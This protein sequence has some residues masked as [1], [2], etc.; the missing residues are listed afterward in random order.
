M[1]ICW[2]NIENMYLSRGKNGKRYLRIGSNGYIEQIDIYISEQ[3]KKPPALVYS[4]ADK[5]GISKSKAEDRWEKPKES[6]LDDENHRDKKILMDWAN[7]GF[8]DG[9]TIRIQRGKSEI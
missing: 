4:I 5:M 2:E 1:K 8:A 6:Y 9:D 3:E 7:S